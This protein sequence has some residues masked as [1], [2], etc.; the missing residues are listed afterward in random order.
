[1]KH[2][3][4]CGFTTYSLSLS[5]FVPAT[6]AFRQLDPPRC[7]NHASKAECWTQSCCWTPKWTG[8]WDGFF[9]ATAKGVKNTQEWCFVVFVPFHFVELFELLV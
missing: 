1:M 7:R 8:C 5:L 3:I 9:L 2:A 6:V 4:Y